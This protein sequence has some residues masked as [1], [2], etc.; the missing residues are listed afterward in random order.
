M[1]PQ[2]GSEATSEEGH[3]PGAFT[4]RHTIERQGPTPLPR[5]VID[6]ARD[7][8]SRRLPRRRT[9]RH[10]HT[11]PRECRPPAPVQASRHTPNVTD[12]TGGT[13]S[14]SDGRGNEA[15]RHPL[16]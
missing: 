6:Q 16:R 10:H 12:R 2:K 15:P 13:M 8:V 14:V 4:R 7:E 5:V 9:R 11:F 1:A 3:S